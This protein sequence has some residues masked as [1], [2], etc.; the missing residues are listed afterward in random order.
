MV[1][2]QKAERG[3][4]WREPPPVKLSLST[5]HPRST[6]W[7]PNVKLKCWPKHRGWMYTWGGDYYAITAIAADGAVSRCDKELKVSWKW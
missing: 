4:S 6:G 5:V 2:K 1:K 7:V 3:Q